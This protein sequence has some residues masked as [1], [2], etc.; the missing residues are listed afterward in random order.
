MNGQVFTTMGWLPAEEVILQ[1]TVTYEDDK[2]K[3]ERTDKYLKSTGEWV[4]N[5]L[6]VIIKT[7]Q[8]FNFE[9]GSFA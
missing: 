8:E 7:G 9:L 4:G 3:A 1:V 6:N 5:D 2:A